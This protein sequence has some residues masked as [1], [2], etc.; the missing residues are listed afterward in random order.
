MAATDKTPTILKQEITVGRIVDYQL[1]P[2][3]VRPAIVVAVY[4]GGSFVNLQVFTDAGGDGYDN[5]VHR[6][7]VVEGTAEGTW[8]WPTRK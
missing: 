6:S 8:A 7:S 3:V 2:G 4:G 1:K 5:V